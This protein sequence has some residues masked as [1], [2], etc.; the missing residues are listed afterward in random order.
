MKGRDKANFTHKIIRLGSRLPAIL[1]S[2]LPARLNPAFDE[3]SWNSFPHCK[4]IITQP[5]YFKECFEVT[6]LT[7]NKEDL[8]ETENIHNLSKKE[9]EQR[10]VIRVDIANDQIGRR[11]YE[12]MHDPAKY[13][14]VKDKFRSELGEFWLKNLNLRRPPL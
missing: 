2:V 1:Q 11:D 4:T 14:N 6:V 3:K 13:S 7:I 12:S 8:G 10:E 5:G 9:L